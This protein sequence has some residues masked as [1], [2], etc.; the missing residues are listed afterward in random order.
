M[1]FFIYY[2][3]N[4]I[5]MSLISQQQFSWAFMCVKYSLWEFLGDTYIT[6][7]HWSLIGE[8]KLKLNADLILHNYKNNSI[9]I[10]K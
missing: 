9:L 7:M 8:L 1:G 3:N 10:S 4:K 5:Y 6:V 2:Y